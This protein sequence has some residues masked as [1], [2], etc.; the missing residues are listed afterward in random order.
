MTIEN[1]K[2]FFFFSQDKWQE[3]GHIFPEYIKYVETEICDQEIKEPKGAEL[4]PR[5]NDTVK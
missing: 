1:I 5:G 3:S 4:F 2:D